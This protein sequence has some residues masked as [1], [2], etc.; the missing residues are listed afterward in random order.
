M[1]IEIKYDGK[2]PNLC[3]GHL[4]VVIDGKDWDFGE[5]VLKSGG[6][7][8]WKTGERTKGPWTVKNWPDNFP[9]GLKE[10]V[11]S[12]INDEIEWGCCGGC[13]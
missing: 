1:K 8:N 2:W 7:T 9:E 11:V 13:L 4:I 3:R 6:T 5:Y 12:K 10:A